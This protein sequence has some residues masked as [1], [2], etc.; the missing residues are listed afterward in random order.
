MND[1]FSAEETAKGNAAL[2]IDGN[3]VMLN[4]KNAKEYA[5]KII[6]FAAT[7]VSVVPGKYDMIGTY[8]LSMPGLGE[9]RNYKCK[10][11]ALSVDVEAGKQYDI[12]IDNYYEEILD[13]VLSY[14][15]YIASNGKKFITGCFPTQL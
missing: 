14:T 12:G 6:P 8:S 1:R 3:K 13:E 11:A 10:N 15:E 4:G 7:S 9:N 2:H 5:S